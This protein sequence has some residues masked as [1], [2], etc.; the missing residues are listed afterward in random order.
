[1]GEAGEPIRLSVLICTYKRPAGLRALLASLWPQVEGR[2]DRETVIINDGTDG[3]AYRAVIA[4]FP[5]VSYV[6]LPKNVGIAEA[7]NEA[8][9]HARGAFIVFTDD[10]CVVPPWWLDWLQ[11]RLDFSP[12]LDIVA[13]TTLPP[14]NEKPSFLGRVRAHYQY[15]PHSWDANGMPMLVTAN[16]AIRRSLFQ[17]L[18]GFG[19]VPFPGA[20]EDT[21]FS[22]RANRAMARI[23]LDHD[24]YVEHEIADGWR[25]VLRRYWRYGYAN[26][27]IATLP[28]AAHLFYDWTHAKRRNHLVNARAVFA[29]MSARSA[30]FSDRRVVRFASI[31]AATLIRVVH[32][33]GL[34]TAL[35]GNAP[36][37]R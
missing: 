31:L 4:G 6:P 20:G 7:R 24:W 14:A 25:V 37:A 3:D 16:V 18:G 2:A 23:A 1:M 5:G 35:K 8:V 9:R 11:A 26:A 32:Y 33:D 19:F 17:A 13:G 10:D 12:E 27:R 34:A 22:I 21:E 30:G 15:L 29:E 36:R 28:N